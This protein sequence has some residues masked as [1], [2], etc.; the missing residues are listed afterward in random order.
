MHVHE[1]GPLTAH[2]V[3]KCAVGLAAKDR[4]HREAQPPFLLHVV[5]VRGVP[6]DGVPIFFEQPSFGSESFVFA[7]TLLIGVVNKEDLHERAPCS[8]LAYQAGDK[9]ERGTRARRAICAPT[10]TQ[11]NG[12]NV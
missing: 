12:T 11:S 3:P 4:T 8:A 6:N 2:Q 10:V 9:T 5:V 7:A 1:V